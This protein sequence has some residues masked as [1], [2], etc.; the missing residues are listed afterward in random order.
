MHDIK[1]PCG[2]CKHKQTNTKTAEISQLLIQREELL[3]RVASEP[4]AQASVDFIDNILKTLQGKPCC[5]NCK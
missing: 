1:K 3:V 2:G 4:T 5:G